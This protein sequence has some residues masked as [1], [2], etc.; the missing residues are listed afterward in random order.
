MPSEQR[1][2]EILADE[3]IVWYQRLELGPDLWS[4]GGVDPR[5]MMRRAKV[6][7]DLTGRSVLD[8]GTSNGGVAFEAE[9]RGASPVV[10]V[11]ICEPTWFGF[12][13]LAEFFGS[14]SRYVRASVYELPSLL[15]EQFDFVVFFGVLYHLRHP[16]LGLD[17]VR[18]VAR[19][20]VFIESA[21]GDDFLPDGIGSGEGLVRFFR[22]SELTDDP[23]NWFA[24]TTAT[25]LDWCR[26]AGLEPELVD[27]QPRDAAPQ[28]C[29]V[30][31]RVVP[32]E[33]E[34]E[35]LSYEVRL[36]VQADLTP[37]HSRQH[38]RRR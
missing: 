31:C 4:P 2:R 27:V 23:S 19:E 38:F 13:T 9:R 17:A 32:G 36:R 37:V 28:R 14:R 25:L 1:A 15:D 10:A 30:R 22:A 20:W 33:P 12:S 21:V 24:P 29:I 11:D 16:L 5:D 7:D 34:Y 8:I 26:S 35:S 3:R 6:P 18:Q